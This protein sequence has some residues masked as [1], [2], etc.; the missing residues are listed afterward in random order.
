MTA[1]TESTYLLINKALLEHSHCHSFAFYLALLLLLNS[2]VEQLQQ[3]PH[4]LRSCN[5]Y[6]LAF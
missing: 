1:W 3:R 2:G 4:C 6:Y 5:I